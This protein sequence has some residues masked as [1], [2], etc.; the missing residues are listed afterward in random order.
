MKSVTIGTGSLHGK[1]VY[2]ARDFQKGEVVIQYHLKP[3]GDAEFENLPE[4][5]K[6]F[7]HTHWNQR[8]LYS[9]PERYVNH[10]SD[11]NTYQDLEK[12]CDIALRDIQ[13]GEMITTN[14]SKDD[15][16]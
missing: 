1:G 4:S 15:I 10:S 16:S 13:Q 5:E 7:V 3:L 9:K 2:A 14:A 12:Q 8:Y 6:D 11:P